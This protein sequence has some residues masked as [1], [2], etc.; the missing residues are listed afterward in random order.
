MK[1]LNAPAFGLALPVLRFNFRGTGRSQGEHDSR[2][3]VEDVGA[4]LA[5]LENA[6]KLPLVAVGFSFGAAMALAAGCART[7]PTRQLSRA[8]PALPR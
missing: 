3:E 6:Y 7:V 4:A 5:W 1:A 8:P 2:A